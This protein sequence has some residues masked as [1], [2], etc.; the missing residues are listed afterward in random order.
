M[1]PYADFAK[2]FVPP[3]NEQYALFLLSPDVASAARGETPQSERRFYIQTAKALVE[4]FISTDDFAELKRMVKTQNDE[5]LKKAEAQMPGLFE[6]VNKGLSEN[7]NLDLNLSLDQIV[8][9]PPHYETERGF[10]YSMILR[11]KVNDENG[12]PSV[13]EG[14]VTATFVHLQGKV[15]FLYVNAE[16][17]ALDWSRSAAQNWADSII[18]ANPS[19][20]AI[21][22]RESKPSRSGFDWSK[23][24]SKAATGAIIGGIVGAFAFLF[25]KKKD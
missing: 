16:K 6:K 25:R 8:P 7:Q 22:A 3:M 10:A 14:T 15:L 5:I 19:S 18:A 2:Q 12:K 13:F 9:L 21:A 20:E 1:Q 23:V 24:F 11:Y 17:A 4:R